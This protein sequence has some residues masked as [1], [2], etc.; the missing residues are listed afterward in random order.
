MWTSMWS[1]CFGMVSCQ[2]C[3][4]VRTQCAAEEV[5]RRQM[6]GRERQCMPV[7]ATVCSIPTTAPYLSGDYY[8]YWFRAKTVSSRTRLPY[9]SCRAVAWQLLPYK[10][11]VGCAR[12]LQSIA[13]RDQL[14]SRKARVKREQTLE[15]VKESCHTTMQ[16]RV[17]FQTPPCLSGCPTPKPLRHG[18]VGPSCP[19]L[20]AAAPV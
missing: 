6:R 13:L 5:L 16:G 3:V 8:C 19:W 20:H 15:G 2:A 14:A 7:R 9:V 4:S 11:R 12:A 17:T 18:H 1:A 10:A